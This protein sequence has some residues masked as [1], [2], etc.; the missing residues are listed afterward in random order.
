MAKV[1]PGV[2]TVAVFLRER[3]ADVDA[4]ELLNGG[5][6]SSAFGFISGGRS[7]VARFGEHGED[8]AKDAIAARWVAPDLPVPRVV[9]ANSRCGSGWA[10]ARK[11]GQSA[12]RVRVAYSW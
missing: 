7:L 1:V 5:D 4:V 6:W 8:Y 10:V 2:S 9:R 12:W 3:F 11:L